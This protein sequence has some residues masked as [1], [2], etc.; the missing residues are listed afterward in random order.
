MINENDKALLA[1]KGITEEKLHQQLE[2]FQKGFPFLR[3]HAAAGIG[4]GI[5]QPSET[6]TEAYLKAWDAYTDDASHR[7][8]KFVPAS[9]AASRMFKNMFAFA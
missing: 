7:I 1:A 4:K 6:D 9:G 5:L 8:V 3:L 2:C